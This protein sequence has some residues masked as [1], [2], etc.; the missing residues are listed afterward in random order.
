MLKSDALSQYGDAFRNLINDKTWSGPQSVRELLRLNK[1]SD[2]RFICAAMDIIGDSASAVDNFLRFGINGPT[3]YDDSGE[4]Y[5]RL[6]GLLSATYL[7]QESVLELYRLMN[8]PNPKEARAKV[9]DLKIRQV[10]NK[11]AS[12]SVNHLNEDTG[13]MEAFAP[14][15]I[16]LENFN[17]EIASL[18]L[19]PPEKIDTREAL[20]EHFVLLTHLMDEIYEKS[21]KTLFKGH[22]TKLKEHQEKLND[23][24]VVKS[25]GMVLNLGESKLIIHGLDCEL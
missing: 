23:L 17:C 3:R 7:Q 12:H 10:R 9:V 8:V 4:K 11:L 5:L 21:Y 1:D 20:K 6:Y 16:T 25:G 19:D 18:T 2:W 13:E 14:V 15:R 22:Q 24:R